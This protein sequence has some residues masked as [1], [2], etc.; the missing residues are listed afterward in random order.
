M[1][2]FLLLLIALLP[3][4]VLAA[5]G[6]IKASSSSTRVT[7]N[8]TVTVTVKVSSTDKLGS[9]QYGLSYDKS[10]LSL[11]SG[12]TNIVG[13]GDGTYS[14]KSYTYK[15]KAIA[16]GTAN[17]KI[18]NPK[19]VD[20]TSESTISTTSGN[21]SLTIKEPVIINYSS[22]NNLKSLSVEGF[23]ISPEFN[24]STL[25]YSVTVKDS[26]TKVKISAEVNDSKAKVSG[27]G[28]VEVKEGSNPF[29]IVVT[30]ENGT[31]KTYKLNVI[32]PEKNPIN[33]TFKIEDNTKGD[34]KEGTNVSYG[35]K[36]EEFSILRKLP[37]NI[38]LNYKVSSTTFNE[39]EVPCLT[40]E[41]LNITLIYLRDSKGNDKFYIYNVDDKSIKFYNEIESNSLN[42]YV[43]EPTKKLDN[44]IETTL[45]INDEEVKAYQI[46]EGS[47]NYIIYGRNIS[48]GKSNF[49][50]YDSVSK[51]LSLYNEDDINY[52]MENYKLYKMIICILAVLIIL[53]LIII[54][55]V[56]SSKH[57][58]NVI[59]KKLT[60]EK[61]FKTKKVR[62]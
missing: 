41:N 21:L 33:Y 23:N 59:V 38:P 54:I 1:K 5:T 58:L 2:K 39:E 43:E 27:T 55:L 61:D 20:W 32:V 30:A 26:T 10:K 18:D 50:T 22:D 45:K 35:F 15:F 57:K 16:E 48:T 51:T 47:S 28:E 60:E 42:I 17:I 34:F 9:W 44:L 62:N 40:N 31:S 49:Y 24:K 52:L 3:L 29:D 36:T 56:N 37:E 6:S 7:L 4:N 8:N 12:D 19:I 25:E 53:L 13:Y 14:S 46:K 11:I